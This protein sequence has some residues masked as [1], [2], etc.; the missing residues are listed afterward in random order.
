MS[1]LIRKK[2]RIHFIH[3]IEPRNAGDMLCY[4]Y[5][6]FHSFFNQYDCIIHSTKDI[7]FSTI[8]TRDVVI[9]ASGGCFE[10]LD[11][12]QESINRL[13]DIND[14]VIAWGC[15]HNAHYDRPVYWPIEFSK[16]KLLSVRDFNY[17]GQLYVP[18][19][20]CLLPQLEKQYEIKRR[21]GLIEHQDFPIL[22]E[23]EKIN[24]REGIDCIIPFIGL[25]KLF[26]QTHI[27]ARIGLCLWEKRLFF[28]T[29][30]QQNLSGSNINLLFIPGIWRRISKSLISLQT[31]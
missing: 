15:G 16:F 6:Y 10:V 5:R 14:N 29:L 2:P 3:V 27:I 11:S 22:L 19:V 1:H 17:P 9:L 24:H 31:S 18:C 21:I 30:F 12:F 4:P 28:I 20:S 25:V 8:H 23:G 7:G 13:L 26:S